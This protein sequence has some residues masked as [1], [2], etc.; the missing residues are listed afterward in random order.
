MNKAMQEVLVRRLE[1]LDDR[2]RFRSGNIDLDR[3]FLRY[4]VRISFDTTLD[5]ALE[6]RNRV[7]CIGVIVD[8]KPDTV[9]FYLSLGFKP[10][11]RR[12]RA[13]SNVGIVR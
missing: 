1:P 7:G 3:F 9:P 5:L 10:I 8:A 2:T 11:I 4:A 6:M 13:R 12:P